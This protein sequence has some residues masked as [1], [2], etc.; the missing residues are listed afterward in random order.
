[1]TIKRDFYQVT[2]L[3][4][5]FVWWD[6]FCSETSSI[7]QQVCMAVVSEKKL[8]CL[9]PAESLPDGHRCSVPS[10]NPQPALHSLIVAL[11]GNDNGRL[12]LGAEA[13]EYGLPLCKHMCLALDF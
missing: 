12:T 6:L 9:S 1:M 7:N 5:Y 3:K 13:K 4:A 11:P 2:T 8:T 10:L